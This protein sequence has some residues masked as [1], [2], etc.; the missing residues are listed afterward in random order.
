[1]HFLGFHISNAFCVQVV[2]V[3]SERDGQRFSFFVVEVNPHIGT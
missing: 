1:M 3:D 2:N